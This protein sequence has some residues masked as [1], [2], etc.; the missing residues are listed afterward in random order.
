VNAVLFDVALTA[1]ILA[2]V[3][4]IGSL[5][6]RR[7]QL[8]WAALLLTQAGW[9]CHT[10]AVIL[11]GVEL[12]RLPVST[13]AEM[14]SLVIWA[15][16]LLDFW[17]ERHRRVRPLSAFVLP[18][19]L[20]LGL[21][22]PT[23]LRSFVLEPPVRSGWVLVHVA[24]LLVGLAALVLNFGGA[25]MYLLMERQ[26]KTKRPG[27]AYYRLPPLET[28]DRLTVATLTVAF[29]FLTVG[30]ALGAF[31]A[32]GAW[33]SVVTFDPLAVFSLVMWVIYA[34]TL[35]GRVLGHWRG[36]R[37]AYLS[38]AGFCAMLVTLSAGVLLHG[39]HG[40]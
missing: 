32:R 5:V 8:A 34:A 16:I 19:V 25:L 6:G 14:I 39:H 23:G 9:I 17:V 12:R 33:G 4:A 20:A 11:R 28:L 37:A 1:Y 3:A 2:A 22:L 36:R 38:I 7:D 26:L 10:G 15:V 24:L 35:L 18:V 31:S 30:L 13:L 40:S 29:P 21:G 27:T